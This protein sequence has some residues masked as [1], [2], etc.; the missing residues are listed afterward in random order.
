[1]AFAG[2]CTGDAKNEMG[3]DYRI[4]SMYISEQRRG[5]QA[6]SEKRGNRPGT[7]PKRH[8]GEELLLEIPERRLQENSR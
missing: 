4:P 6:L 8:G 7:L 5:L 3:Y 2:G 1:M